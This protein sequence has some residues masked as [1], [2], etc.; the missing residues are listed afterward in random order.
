M[1][2]RT[3]GV[4][5]KSTMKALAVRAVIDDHSGSAGQVSESLVICIIAG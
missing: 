4:V 1:Q 3:A 5:A 2:Q